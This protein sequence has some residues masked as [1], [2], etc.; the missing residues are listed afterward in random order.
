MNRQT[1]LIY[2]PKEDLLQYIDT[3][4][5]RNVNLKASDVLEL[6]QNKEKVTKWLNHKE[7]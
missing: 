2:T 6:L 1:K 4:N 3:K 5:N 7:S